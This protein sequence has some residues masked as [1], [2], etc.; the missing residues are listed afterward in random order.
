MQP[1]KKGANHN[2]A[3]KLFLG[4]YSTISEKP[5]DR[6]KFWFWP[7]FKSVLLLVQL[8]KKKKKNFFLTWSTVD[9]QPVIILEMVRD[10]EAWCAAVHG[11]A[12]SWT[13]FSDWTTTNNSGSPVMNYFHY[14]T[15]YTQQSN[16]WLIY[17]HFLETR[18]P[19][20]YHTR[21]KS[22]DVTP[23]PLSSVLST[24][25]ALCHTWLANSNLEDQFNQQFLLS[26]LSVAREKSQLF[27]ALVHYKQLVS[28]LH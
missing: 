5:H 22:P 13:R 1:W 3:K 7:K 17:I 27:V 15:Q 6:Q 14:Y 12:K 4:N 20:I 25:T 8:I 19:F 16:Q 23:M 24:L 11:V 21:N 26:E 18:F 28:K 10:R 2:S 9:L